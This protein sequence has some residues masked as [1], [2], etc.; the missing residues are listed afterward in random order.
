M[1]PALGEQIVG[2]R[3]P[4]LGEQIFHVP[5]TQAEAK[6]EPDGLRDD[7]GRESISVI[8]RRGTVHPVTLISLTST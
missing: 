6:V 2:D 1:V 4:A 8:A 5:E 7:V 3:D